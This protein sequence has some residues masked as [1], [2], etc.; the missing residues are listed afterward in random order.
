MKNMFLNKNFTQKELKSDFLQKKRL[1]HCTKSRE[2]IFMYD[3]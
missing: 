3:F 2:R 1:L